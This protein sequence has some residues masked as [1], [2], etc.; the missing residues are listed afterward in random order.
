ML[1]VFGWY[2]GS[3]FVG[4]GVVLVGE[5]VFFV[6]LGGGV[7]VV[8]LVWFVMWLLMVKGFEF[9]VCLVVGEVIK[10]FGMVVLLVIVVVVFKGL[11]WLFLLIILILVFKMYWVGFVL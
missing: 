10:V 5:V 3:W 7:C 2:V 1:C 8:F 11:Y 6:L 9:I 4:M